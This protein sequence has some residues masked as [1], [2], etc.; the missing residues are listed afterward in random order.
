MQT[1]VDIDERL[2]R[3]ES[4]ITGIQTAI[5]ILAVQSGTDTSR[6]F[7]TIMEA[8]SQVETF[9]KDEAELYSKMSQRV[10][11]FVNRRE[12]KIAEEE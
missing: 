11:S 7:A 4:Q 2:S 8:L 5:Y 10:L 12:V 9:S 6:S 1:H 3:I